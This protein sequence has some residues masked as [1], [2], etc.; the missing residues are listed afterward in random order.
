MGKRDLVMVAVTEIEQWITSEKYSNGDLLPSEGDISNIL[1]LSRPTVRDAIRILE[2]RGFV[3]RIHGVGV[4]VNDRSIDV[5]IGFLTD[6]IQRNN[7]PNKD[8]L[9][10]STLIRPEIVALAAISPT[11][12]DLKTL[13]ECITLIENENYLTALHEESYLRFFETLSLMSKNKLFYTIEQSYNSMLY[14]HYKTTHQ[15][16]LLMYLKNIY[17]CIKNRDGE[18]AKK[19]TLL[20][21][22]VTE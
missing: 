3:D 7:I 18:G 2:T 17:E 19:E 9:A 8:L 13:K 22:N 5:T 1:D 12:E 20:L 10:V 16:G 11:T 4:K 21:L 15:D 14:K 6:M